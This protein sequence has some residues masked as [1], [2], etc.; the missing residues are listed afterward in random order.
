[1]FFGPFSDFRAAPPGPAGV[2]SHR[3]E[4][5]T[6]RAPGRPRLGP[7]RPATP[8]PGRREGSGTPR[9]TVE[10]G[11]SE[12]VAS[13]ELGA[14]PN[15][16]PGFPPRGP[17]RHTFGESY[18]RVLGVDSVE[19]A[20][21]ADLRLGDKADLA[22]DVRG[23]P[24][25]GAAAAAAPGRSQ[26]GRSHAAVAVLLAHLLRRRLQQPPQTQHGGS[27]GSATLPQ[28]PALKPRRGGGGGC[29]GGGAGHAGR[30]GRGLARFA[31]RPVAQGSFAPS[32]I[33]A[34]PLGLV[35]RCRSPRPERRSKER[36]G[37]RNVRI[38]WAGVAPLAVLLISAVAHT[39]SRPF[40]TCPESGFIAKADPSS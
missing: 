30:G 2:L 31:W 17:P 24:A 10:R 3:I 25:H 22:A 19:D 37:P 36:P 32:A 18:G 7:A 12:E 20:L 35:C 6:L 33:L 15:A 8:G 38:L 13:R 21:V 28:P 34:V 29:S 27:A 1:M 39:I 14:A 4:G 26:R 9:R 16:R 11:G 5:G 40:V 23:A